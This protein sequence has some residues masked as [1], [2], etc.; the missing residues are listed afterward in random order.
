MLQ[1]NYDALKAMVLEYVADITPVPMDVGEVA[2][3]EGEQAAPATA[4]REEAEHVDLHDH[5]GDGCQ[6]LPV[7]GRPLRR[8]HAQQVRLPARRQAPPWRPSP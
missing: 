6:P 7:Q 1:P 5:Q 3:V 8:W 4:S 2:E